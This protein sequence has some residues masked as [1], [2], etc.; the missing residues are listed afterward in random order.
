VPPSYL[1]PR[2]VNAGI[3]SALARVDNS[4]RTQVLKSF[5]DMGV[6]LAAR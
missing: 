3:L 2:A 6:T 5:V 4:N 1:T